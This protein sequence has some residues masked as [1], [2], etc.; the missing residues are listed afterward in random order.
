[1]A[2]IK[3]V[4]KI[5]GVSTA[6]VS[7]V[8]NNQNKVGAQSRARVKKVIEELG[9]K[10]SSTAKALATQYNN[11]IGIIT[12]NLS[13]SFFS[14]LACGAER[15]A[16]ENGCNLVMRNS[17]YE[18]QSEIDAIESL[19][20]SNCDAIILH[21]E[22]SDEKTLI[23]LCDKHPGLVIINRF[24]PQIAERCVWLDNINSSQEATNY[25]LDF[26]HK[27]LAVITSIYQ[28]RD[29]ASRTIGVK[30]AL[31]HRNLTLDPD[32]IEESTANMEGGQLAVN[33]L[34]EKGVKFTAIVAYNDL[35]AVGAVH[36]LFDAGLRVPEDVSVVG[37]DDLPIARAC[38]PQLTTMH[39]PIEEM[40]RYAT[41]LAIDNSK[42]ERSEHKNTHLFLSKLAT[43]QSVAK[44]V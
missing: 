44:L 37:F 31:L 34:L 40:A 2:T 5:A 39:Y 24:I 27:N 4:A 9:Y 13:M 15:A 3:D 20:E 11:T 23:E 6:T 28:N 10:P 38:R 18:T 30:Q 21:S 35:M 1:M 41:K 33:A 7:R 32:A 8:I 12:P 19:K 16:R 17:L 26:G 22:Y 25:L 36:A 29:P 14:S 42:G 43:R